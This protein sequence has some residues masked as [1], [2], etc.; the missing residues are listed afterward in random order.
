M[1]FET[2]SWWNFGEAISKSTLIKLIQIKLYSSFFILFI[3]LLS[4]HFNHIQQK[5][6]LRKQYFS[7]TIH[8]WNENIHQ[9]ISCLQKAT[10]LDLLQDEK[11]V[12]FCHRSKVLKNTVEKFI[13]YRPSWILILANPSEVSLGD[14]NTS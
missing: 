5:K 10:K 3:A 12:S 6:N 14:I 1:T 13:V 7:A 4:F 2:L 11:I 8:H 9:D